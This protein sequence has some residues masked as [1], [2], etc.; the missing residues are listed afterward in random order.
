[1]TGISIESLEKARRA[2]F[3]ELPLDVQTIV[4]MIPDDMIEAVESLPGFVSHY[5][6]GTIASKLPGN[7]FG[8]CGKFSFVAAE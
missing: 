6:F 3:N 8:H 1:M 7:V 4:L 5:R 2:A